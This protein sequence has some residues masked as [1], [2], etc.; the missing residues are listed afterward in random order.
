MNVSNILA[1]GNAGQTPNA[2]KVPALPRQPSSAQNDNLTT[3]PS[4]TSSID[5]AAGVSPSANAA[6]ATADPT[7]FRAQL[8]LLQ[9]SDEIGSTNI[10]EKS[11][12][13][14]FLF[15]P[16]LQNPLL[17]ARRYRIVK[18]LGKGSYGKVFLAWDE[19]RQYASYCCMDILY[20]L[21]SIRY[22][23]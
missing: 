12:L 18:E 10:A 19:R 4:G 6:H 13:T 3:Q 21:L 1:F 7:S 20:L 5:S 16:K 23:V 15:T 22:S 2:D 8:Q 9:H 17:S 14:T 11:R